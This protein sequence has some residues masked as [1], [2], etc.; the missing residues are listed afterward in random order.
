MEQKGTKNKGKYAYGHKQ[1]NEKTQ[2]IRTT[3]FKIVKGP[4]TL[5]ICLPR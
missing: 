3:T 5:Q 4:K 2:Q 1:K